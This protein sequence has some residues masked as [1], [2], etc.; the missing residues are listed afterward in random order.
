MICPRCHET[1]YSWDHKCPWE[2]KLDKFDYNVLP[3]TQ[4]DRELLK[5]MLIKAD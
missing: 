3:L 1:F 4:W 2:R 5:G